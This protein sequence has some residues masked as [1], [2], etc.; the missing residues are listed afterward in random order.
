MPLF[1]V[2]ITVR[3]TLCNIEDHILYK[4]IVL[5]QSIVCSKL[6][7]RILWPK[8]YVCTNTEIQKKKV[9]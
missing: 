5:Q 4:I 6:G 7:K 9:V 2:I 1:P 3:F 8:I